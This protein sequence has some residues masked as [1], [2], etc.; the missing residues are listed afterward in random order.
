MHPL[1]VAAFQTQSST[2]SRLPS[3]TQHLPSILTRWLSFSSGWYRL[4]SRPSCW[5]VINVGLLNGRHQHLIPGRFSSWH[6]RDYSSCLWPHLE[7]LRPWWSPKEN[8]MR[9]VS[10]NWPITAQINTNSSP[11]CV[12]KQLLCCPDNPDLIQAVLS[13]ITTSAPARNF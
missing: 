1:K 6:L 2:A 12:R 3:R 4:E 13:W 11:Q 5:F 7:F 8:N 9:G 10:W